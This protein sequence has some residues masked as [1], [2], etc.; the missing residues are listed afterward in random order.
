MWTLR[1]EPMMA[2]DRRRRSHALLQGAGYS[3]HEQLP[4]LLEEAG[5]LRPVRVVADRALALYAFLIFLDGG[6]AY[7]EPIGR[8]LSEHALWEALTPQE[9]SLIETRGTDLTE[10]QKDRFWRGVESLHALCWA[11][12]KAADLPVT[13]EVPD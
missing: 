6:E 3:L 7:R 1:I 10:A 2:R 11:L 4:P 5:A 8:W 12:G 9:R 13:A